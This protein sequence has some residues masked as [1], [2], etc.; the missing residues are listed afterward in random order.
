MFQNQNLAFDKKYQFHN[1]NQYL[2][3]DVHI[4]PEGNP[5]VPKVFVTFSASVHVLPLSTD[6]DIKISKSCWRFE[7]RNQ[8]CI[9]RSTYLQMRTI[10]LDFPLH[11]RSNIWSKEKLRI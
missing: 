6:L 4:Q 8:H 2:Q 9:L 7:E 1:Q 5:S 10:K 3:D 11:T